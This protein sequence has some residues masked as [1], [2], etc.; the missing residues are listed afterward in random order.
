MNL[1]LS[2][3]GRRGTWSKN[4]G[5][6]QLQIFLVDLEGGSAAKLPGVEHIG[7]GDDTEVLEGFNKERAGHWG[8]PRV[9][10]GVGSGCVCEGV[11]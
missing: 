5:V 8:A 11:Y 6:G 10:S 9:V 4:D 3:C 2:M 1:M 7:G